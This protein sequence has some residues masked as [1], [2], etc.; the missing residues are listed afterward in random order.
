MQTSFFNLEAQSPVLTFPDFSSTAKPFILQTDTSSLGIGAVLEPTGKVVAYASHVLTKAEKSYSV[1]LQ[2]CFAI[3]YALKQ[4]RQYL[5]GCLFTLR[6][7]HTPLQR[8]SSQKMEGLLCRWTLSLQEFD[9]NI[10]YHEDATNA[11]ADAL[12]C[13]QVAS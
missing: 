6:T 5:L 11:N 7:D 13:C 3:V 10:E 9:I 8:L 12:S 1:I 4:F 2:E